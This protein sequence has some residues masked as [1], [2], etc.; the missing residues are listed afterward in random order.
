M[1]MM[2][3]KLRR[4][5]T[6]DDYAPAD[7]KTT[8][9]RFHPMVCESFVLK[10]LGKR[11]WRVTLTVSRGPFKGSQRVKC[12]YYDSPFGFRDNVP[13]FLTGG[14]RHATLS[15]LREWLGQVLGLPLIFSPDTPPFYFYYK[16]EA[17]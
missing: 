6:W 12:V 3:I 17:L 1:K 15:D 4:G 5:R 14:I 16:I 11:P 9:A 8:E 10:Q 2:S 13:M 7:I